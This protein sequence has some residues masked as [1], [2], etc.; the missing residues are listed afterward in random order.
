MKKQKNIM[1]KTH[2]NREIFDWTSML[3]SQSPPSGLPNLFSCFWRKQSGE[4]SIKTATE[5]TERDK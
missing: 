4:K 5:W 2:D 1:K 3:D